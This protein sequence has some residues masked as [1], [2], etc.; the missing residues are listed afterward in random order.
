MALAFAGILD[1]HG[2]SSGDYMYALLFMVSDENLSWYLNDNIRANIKAPPTNLKEDDD[3]MESNK[4]H[5][6]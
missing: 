5:G 3:F 6:D 2:D 4:M 1:V